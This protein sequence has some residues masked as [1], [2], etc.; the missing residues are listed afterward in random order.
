MAKFSDNQT[1]IITALYDAKGPI[2]VTSFD[3][4]ALAG[5][6]KR[7]FVTI[8][9]GEF[10]E[11]DMRDGSPDDLTRLTDKQKAVYNG[12]LDGR[13]PVSNFDR[14][15]VQALTRRGVVDV[16]TIELAEATAAGIAAAEA[17][18]F[19]AA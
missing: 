10:V 11:I 7:G 14:R 15:S 9:T 5:L 3:R 6:V 18:L 2:A 19:N 8:T 17:L 16:Q 4:R 13:Q 12:L 1:T